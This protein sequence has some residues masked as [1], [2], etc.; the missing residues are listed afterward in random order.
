MVDVAHVGLVDA[1]PEGDRGDDDVP[2]G[3][4]PPVLHR[5]PVLRRH[6]GVI[7][8]GGKPGG[9]EQRGD[10]E[11]RALQRHVDDRRAG[12]ARTQRVDQQL[13]ARGRRHGRR[14][15]RQIGSVEA[16]DDRVGLVDAEARA[17]VGDDRRCR[18]GGQREH[19]LGAELARAPGELQV[20]GPEVV[21]PLRDAVR[22]VDREKGDSR[23]GE[24]C[25]EAFVVEALRGDIEQLQAARAQ[26]LRGVP[27]L[28]EAEARVEPGSLDPLTREEVELVLHQRDQRRDDDRDTVEQ[29]G[30]KLVA[31][32][33]TGAG[34]EDRERGA[35]GEERLDD[36]LL[37][38]AER[39]EA[40]PVGEN[41]TRALGSLHRAATVA[42]AADPVAPDD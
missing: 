38:R 23:L 27:Q 29:E 1:H 16:G 3:T 34:G 32:A 26:A 24:L 42:S 11:R 21:P 15:Q 25:E 40:E 2:V 8:A 22:L 37:A 7:G 9:S 12:R 13:V 17:D 18:G 14:Q 41:V 10:T 31:E 39:V 28:L 36:L 30:G 4:R 19:P 33:L 5:G 35:A 6:A 20:V